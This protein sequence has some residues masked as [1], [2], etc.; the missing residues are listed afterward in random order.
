M[1]EEAY[2]N[3]KKII[4]TYLSGILKL[5]VVINQETP[6]E[7]FIQ[8]SNVSRCILINLRLRQSHMQIKVFELKSF[9][10]LERNIEDYSYN[11]EQVWYHDT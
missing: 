9:E 1:S 8:Y 6:T 5:F 3:P 10:M 11:R 2:T 4:L 7:M